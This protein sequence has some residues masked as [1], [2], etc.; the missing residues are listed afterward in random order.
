M[1]AINGC[2]LAI[3]SPWI[4][5]DYFC[6]MMFV[7]SHATSNP[8]CGAGRKKLKLHS[9]VSNLVWSGV[10]TDFKYGGCE[11]IYGAHGEESNI[12]T[13]LQLLLP[14]R[15]QICSIMMCT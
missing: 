8:D 10:H 1:G 15:L 13:L 7:P 2:W 9:R 11:L 12:T 6:V 14:L 5:G 4:I 3:S